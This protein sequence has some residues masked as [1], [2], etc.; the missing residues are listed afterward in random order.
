[1]PQTD[2]KKLKRWEE[3]QA[4]FD[5][6]TKR[7]EMYKADA[8]RYFARMQIVEK[9][10]EAVKTA[11]AD[12]KKEVRYW[13]ANYKKELI[14]KKWWKFACQLCAVGLLVTLTVSLV[15]V[16][17]TSVLSPNDEIRTIPTSA[18]N[19]KTPGYVLATVNIYNGEL[20]GSGV[21]ISQGDQKAAVLSAAHNFRGNLGGFCWVYFANGT[22]CKGT[23]QA[24]DRQKD[25][26]LLEIP[27]DAVLAKAYIPENLKEAQ[28]SLT[29]VGYSDG[30]GP[31][32]RVLS[33]N[34]TYRRDATTMWDL[35]VVKGPFW[36]GDSG[37]GVFMGDALVGVALRRNTNGGSCYM[38]ACAHNEILEFLRKN[39]NTLAGC[40]SWSAVPAAYDDVDRPPLWQPTPNIPIYVENSTTQMIEDLQQQLAEVKS[41]LKQVESEPKS[42]LK[43]PSEIE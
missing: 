2:D 38:H 11:L 7:K 16:R 19:Q 3:I 42:S 36:N 10:W 28:G 1:M 23:L 26:A 33:Y 9:R 20:Q 29:G 41:S 5:Q 31:N 21:V 43:R 37:S 12:K 40:G 35:K 14:M 4:A 30:K 13:K 18:Q 39:E 24:I 17:V 8:A 34:K 22:Y 25:L 15:V 32:F 27:A 6:L